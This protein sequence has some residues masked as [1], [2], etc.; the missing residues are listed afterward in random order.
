MML[1]DFEKTVFI[2]RLKGLMKEKKIT[3]QKLSEM[4]KEK[5]CY[6]SR[7]CICLWL[8]RKQEPTMKNIEVISSCLD[9]SIAYLLGETS[10]RNKEDMYKEWNKSVSCNSVEKVK[11]LNALYKYLEIIGIKH[12]IYS[13]PIEQPKIKDVLIDDKQSY[14]V[15]YSCDDLS[16]EYFDF[17]NY[18]LIEKIEQSIKNLIFYKSDKNKG[19]SENG[20]K[21]DC[22]FHKENFRK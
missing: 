9:V 6:I 7:P 18:E 5:G 10:F 15:E 20:Q 13:E 3:Q 12:S 17:E 22:Y 4:T 1:G 8:A 2:N 19:E 21:N 14:S 11:K 16:I